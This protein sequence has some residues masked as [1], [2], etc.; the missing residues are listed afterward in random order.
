MFDFTAEFSMEIQDAKQLINGDVLRRRLRHEFCW[1]RITPGTEFGC[2][3]ESSLVIL[4]VF[5]E[6]I[7]EFPGL[8]S[9][10]S[11]S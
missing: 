5:R 8:V 9:E 6:E 11:L 10:G 4:H 2:E 3:R 7:F 1:E